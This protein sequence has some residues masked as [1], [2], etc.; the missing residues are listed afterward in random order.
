[1]SETTWSKYIFLLPKIQLLAVS[2]FKQKLLKRLYLHI[3]FNSPHLQSQMGRVSSPTPGN[4]L[5][6][7]VKLI[8]R[9]WGG[10]GGTC[11]GTVWWRRRSFLQ[12]LRILIRSVM[13]LFGLIRIRTNRPDPDLTKKCHITRNKS[14]EKCLNIRY[15]I[16][17]F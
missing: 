13:N 11:N 15:L 7:W 12:V 9:G 10:G 5:H 14:F 16:N 1:M 4:I 6:K 3:M 2:L 8:E 17:K